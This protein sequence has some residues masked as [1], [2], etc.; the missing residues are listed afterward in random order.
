MAENEGVIVEL[1]TTM[2]RG[3]LAI[4]LRDAVQERWSAEV[5][6]IG[7]CGSMAHGDDTESSDVNLVV[8][9]FRPR[10]GPKPA[11]RIVDGIPVD[12]RVTTAEEGLARPG[13]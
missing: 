13:C 1:D 7:L 6:S 3:S 10:T 8:I 9:T 11:R 4:R 2:P 5:Q 12:M